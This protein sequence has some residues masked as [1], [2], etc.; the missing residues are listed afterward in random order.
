MSHEPPVSRQA[1][2]EL[3]REH[4]MLVHLT[5]ELEL[6]IYSLGEQDAPSR[7]RVAECQQAAGRLIGQLRQTLFRFDQQ[8]YPLLEPK[9]PAP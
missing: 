6:R 2:D 3:I 9:L 8:I 5:N 4:Q 7:E 1:F